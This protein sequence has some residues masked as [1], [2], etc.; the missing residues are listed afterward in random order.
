MLTDTGCCGFNLS[1]EKTTLLGLMTLSMPLVVIGCII[2]PL[3]ILS[4]RLS[5]GLNKIKK[6]ITV[7]IKANFYLIYKAAL[8]P[9]TRCSLAGKFFSYS[10]RVS[11]AIYRYFNIAVLTVLWIVTGLILYLL[12]GIF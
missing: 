5:A 8:L 6:V 2:L 4:G 12:K 11:G 7:L 10:P 1:Q 3:F 9:K